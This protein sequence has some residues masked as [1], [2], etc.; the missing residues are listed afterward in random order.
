MLYPQPTERGK[1]W[2]PQPHGYQLDSFLLCHNGNS[3]V[4]LFLNEYY[5][6]YLPNISQVTSPFL[7]LHSHLP[8]LGCHL[9]PEWL[10][11]PL[12]WLPLLTLAP[13]IHSP[14]NS[15]KEFWS[16][17]CHVQHPSLA[18]LC[19]EQNTKFCH[20]PQVCTIFCSAS[21]LIF[22][23]ATIFS[24]VFRLFLNSWNAFCSFSPQGLCIC[25]SHCFEGS[26]SHF[27]TLECLRGNHFPV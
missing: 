5:W 8:N 23:P 14:L 4:G 6:F 13:V 2:N 16:G 17:H 11:Q 24:I 1:R 9:P 18:S 7:Y 10:Q 21:S 19:L 27:C 25:C 3:C 15:W 20:D 12:S 22:P 26:L